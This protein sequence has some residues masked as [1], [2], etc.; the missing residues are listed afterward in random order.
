MRGELKDSAFRI[1]L[2]IRRGNL[3]EAVLH[4]EKLK[5][6]FKIYQDAKV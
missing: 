6:E 3:E 4:I 2:A 1:E 5:S